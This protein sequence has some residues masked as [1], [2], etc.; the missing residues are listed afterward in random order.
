MPSLTISVLDQEWQLFA[1]YKLTYLV[2][3]DIRVILEYRL[4][5]ERLLY[6]NYYT[7]FNFTINQCRNV[8][9]NSIFSFDTL[10]GFCWYCWIN[11]RELIWFILSCTILWNWNSSWLSICLWSIRRH[12]KWNQFNF[13]SKIENKYILCHSKLCHNLYGNYE[14]CTARYSFEILVDLLDRCW[15]NTR[16]SSRY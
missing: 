7:K 11:S 4:D 5:R 9:T 8:R 10:P 2:V 1:E 13:K 15:C 16:F 6:I 14:Y 3:I 12:L